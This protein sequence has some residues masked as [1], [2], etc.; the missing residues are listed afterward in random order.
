MKIV[1]SYWSCHKT[2]LLESNAGWVSPEFNIMSWA[3]SCLQLKKHYSDVTLYADSTSAKLLIDTLALPYSEVV[4][5]LDELNTADPR[6]WA[7]PKI[8][9]YARQE[10]PFL[11]VDGDAFIW[12]R[13]DNTLMSGELIAQN[14]E[15]STDYYESIMQS[16]ESSL[17]Y[18]PEELLVDRKS[19]TK[20]YAYNAG[21]MGGHDVGFYRQYAEEAMR[22]INRN[23]SNFSKINVINFNIFFEQYLFYCLA[24][25]G[26]K[27]VHVLIEEIIGDNRYVGLGDFV[28]VPHTKHYLHLLGGYKRT[29]STCE[30]M[31][32]RLRMDYPD[33][34]YR[35]IDLFKRHQLPLRNDYYWFEPDTSEQSLLTKHELLKTAYTN[36]TISSRQESLTRRSRESVFC[37]TPFVEK[38]LADAQADPSLAAT[39][40]TPQA[41]FTDLNAFEET[42]WNIVDTSFAGISSTYLLARD[43][44]N[45]GYSEYVFADTQTAYE[46]ILVSD[47]LV[48]KIDSQFNWA[49]IGNNKENITGIFRLIQTESGE[50]HTL[51]V[52]ECDH[53]IG[54]SLSVID[55][56]DWLILQTLSEQK[57][58]RELFEQIKFA[59]DADDLEE[60][61]PEFER[62]IFERIKNGLLN[63]SIKAILPVV[64]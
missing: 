34:Y 6:L 26:N 59:F 24:K 22:F 35:I 23:E 37:R 15:V 62:L 64:E 54:Y 20:I 50:F 33:Y 60:S 42:L 10:R 30:Q 7:L 29:L 5:A 32:S 49:L 48:Q 53:Q 19:S 8:K 9:T 55:D 11:H 52:P 12:K 21:I 44:V 51:V 1:Q 17:T 18:F 61:K 38:M 58:I 16:L 4:C 28:D 46:K 43:I 3:L 40:A 57:T 47:L 13:F 36:N 27:K 39:L 56:L 63:K 31:A 45:A 14:M 25:R 2:N 41:Y